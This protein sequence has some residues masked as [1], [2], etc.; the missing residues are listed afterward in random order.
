[1]GDGRH[2]AARRAEGEPAAVVRDP[3]PDA[4]LVVAG[5]REVGGGA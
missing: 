1:M 5:G 3:R 2:V 4:F